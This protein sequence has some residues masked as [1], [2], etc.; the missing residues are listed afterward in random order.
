[1]LIFG[2][3]ASYDSSPDHLVPWQPTHRS[4][5]ETEAARL[6]L[7][8]NLFD[9][10][11]GHVMHRFPD[12]Q[13]IIPLLRKRD[14]NVSVE[15]VLENLQAVSGKHP[16]GYREMA[17]I[18]YYLQWMIWQ[19]E[20]DWEEVH[21]GVTNYKTLM[22][23]IR[24]YCKEPRPFYF[25]TFNYDTML[26]KAIRVLGGQIEAIQDY[27]NSKDYKLFKVH[28]SVNWG[29]IISPRV[30]FEPL[31]TPYP[32]ETARAVIRL[33][34]II[35]ASSESVTN[36]YQMIGSLKSQKREDP[37][38]F[39]AIAIPL[40]SKLD[41]EL[42]PG[43]LDMLKQCIP[44]VSKLL[45]IGWRATDAPFL[46]LLADLLPPDVFL[47]VVC[48]T[49]RDGREVVDRF[50]AAGI[51]IKDHGIQDGGFTSFVRSNAKDFLAR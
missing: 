7:A 20:L 10:R 28:G 47:H 45:L 36:H 21:M 25:V 4:V 13:T 51:R 19:C 24:Q 46:E 9:E 23:L 32:E 34:N 39:P 33:A 30:P 3:G 43:H 16:Q 31:H 12:C 14:E 5:R 8:N 42:P 11:F 6:P 1:M 2:A 26:E 37:P 17:A 40:E 35:L 38:W 15:R 50:H 27:I 18:R 49:A 48:G 44:Q 29:K 22:Y 41:F